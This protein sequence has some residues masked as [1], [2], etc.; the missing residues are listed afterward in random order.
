MAGSIITNPK[1][2]LPLPGGHATLVVPRFLPTAPWAAWPLWDR[3]HPWATSYMK[4][5]CW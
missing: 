4:C 3:T 5:A 1:G 2:G